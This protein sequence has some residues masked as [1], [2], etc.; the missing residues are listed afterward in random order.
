MVSAAV[1]VGKVE[2]IGPGSVA[3]RLS[4]GTLVQARNGLH[5]RCPPNATVLVAQ[6]SD[7]RYDVIG[8]ER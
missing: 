7:G 3:V 2:S 6:S 1:S 5:A 8:R 4:D